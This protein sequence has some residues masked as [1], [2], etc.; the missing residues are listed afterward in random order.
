MTPASGN[1]PPTAYVP[2]PVPN[3]VLPSPPSGPTAAAV[4]IDGGGMRD[5]AGKSRHGLIP[6]EWTDAMAAAMTKGAEKYAPRNWERGMNPDFMVDCAIRHLTK[7]RKGDRFDEG[8]GGT[9]V[10][11]LAL[12]AWNLLAL[13]SYD[14]RGM[15][16]DSFFE[17]P[18]VNSVVKPTAVEAKVVSPTPVCVK[19]FHAC[20][21]ARCIGHL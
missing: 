21:C 16:P 20:G 13:M 12:A 18:L 14:A 11:H 17:K 5:N 19:P 6:T 7:F 4:K 15:L 1:P 9:D 8:A 10:H 2:R 3:Y